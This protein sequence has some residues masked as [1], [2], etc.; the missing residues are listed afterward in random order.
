MT[1][2][3]LIEL[4]D[5]VSEK[6]HEQIRAMGMMV[7]AEI[8]PYNESEE[9]EYSSAQTIDKAIALGQIPFSLGYELVQ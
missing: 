9:D 5:G 6:H 7:G 1:L 3:E 4:H 8:P 2:E